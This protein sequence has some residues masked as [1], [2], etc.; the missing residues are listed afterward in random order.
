MGSPVVWLVMKAGYAVSALS[1]TVGTALVLAGLALG[2][3]VHA[4]ASVRAAAPDATSTADATPEPTVPPPTPTPTPVP[5]PTPR[6][7]DGL[8]SQVEGLLQAAGADGG[9]TLIEMGAGAAQSWS[10]NGDESFVAAS[11]YKLPL[12]M[13]E[14]QDIVSGQASPNDTLCYES[15]DWEDGWFS[16]Y[17][18]G[19]CYTRGELDQR[20]GIYSDNTAA[21]ILVRY[22]GGTDALSAYAQ[23]HG[24]TESAF[25][26][27]NS[28]TSS[29]LARLWQNEAAGD[30]GGAAAQRYLYS[31]LTNTAYED[32]IPAGVHQ[33]T[34]VVHKIGI[35]D[36]EVND[37][38]LIL[39]GPRGAYV[40]SICT[41]AGGW[42][43]VASL[44]EAVAQFEG[45]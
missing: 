9:V 44:A 37:A 20:A 27:P 45:T 1:I 5:A 42:P 21:H 14:A 32:G 28:T 24:A 19:S 16:D 13:E 8:Q 3:S 41:D 29:D 31:L 22:D 7:L 4:P 43:L 10:L 39:N 25:Y 34:T 23:A 17:T 6:S 11:T 18:E 15:D 26:D 30:A 12:L 36:G 33:G 40:L 35:L 38:G 2:A